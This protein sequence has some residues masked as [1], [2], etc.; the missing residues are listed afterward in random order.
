MTRWTEAH[1]I[2]GEVVLDFANTVYRRKPELGADLL[3]ETSLA[4]WLKHTGLGDGASLAEAR[5]LRHHLWSLFE[6]QASDQAKVARHRAG[7]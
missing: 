5:E 2:A 4:A 6:A 7:R 3:D 1:F